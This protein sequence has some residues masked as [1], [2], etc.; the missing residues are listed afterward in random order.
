MEDI[1]GSSSGLQQWCTLALNMTERRR[2]EEA[3]IFIHTTAY[4][5]ANA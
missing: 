1:A 3:E 4:R 5:L 2:K